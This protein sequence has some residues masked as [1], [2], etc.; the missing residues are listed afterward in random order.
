MHHCDC[1]ELA[2]SIPCFDAC[3]Y[4]Q[5]MLIAATN[6]VR[7]CD[8]QGGCKKQNKRSGVTKT[9]TSTTETKLRANQGLTAQFHVLR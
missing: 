9:V 1:I 3:L 2:P 8:Q 5:E 6:A 7:L 4:A